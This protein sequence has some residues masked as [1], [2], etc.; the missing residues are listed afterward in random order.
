M[1]VSIKVGIHSAFLLHRRPNA[2][3]LNAYTK[4]VSLKLGDDATR[5]WE[6]LNDKKI[7]ALNALWK[8]GSRKPNFVQARL[9]ALAFGSRCQGIYNYP[10]NFYANFI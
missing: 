6:D 4:G 10:L 3:A 7:V 2:Y 9:H 1:H 5:M 8:N